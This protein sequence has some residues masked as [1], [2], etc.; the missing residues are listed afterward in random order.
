MS[1]LRASK[2]LSSFFDRRT[3]REPNFSSVVKPKMC[4]HWLPVVTS[5]IE[6]H[7][8]WLREQYID[9]ECANRRSGQPRTP[10]P[11]HF[12][13]AA[14]TS[15]FTA[16]DSRFVGVEVLACQAI[17]ACRHRSNRRLHRQHRSYPEHS[18]WFPSSP[19]SAPEPPIMVGE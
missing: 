4:T 17:V 18:T 13:S 15:A 5:I 1:R 7:A 6:R 19:V 10:V 11:L 8:I 2:N 9:L 3:G 16:F 12:R 14:K